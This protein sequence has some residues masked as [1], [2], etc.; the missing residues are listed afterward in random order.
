MGREKKTD[1]EMRPILEAVNK[2]IEERISLGRIAKRLGMTY[3]ALDGLLK[4]H[5]KDELLMEVRS[6][7]R[8]GGCISEE[9]ARAR[10]QALRDCDY[11]VA[12]AAKVC[13]VERTAMHQYFR[14]QVHGRNGARCTRQDYIELCE[15]FLDDVEDWE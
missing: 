5:G 8:H 2:G 4:R 3:Q 6:T 1:A 10:F 13:G 11:N 14:K 15:D 9:E 7:H 12:K